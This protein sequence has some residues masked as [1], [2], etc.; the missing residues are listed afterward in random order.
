MQTIETW[1]SL[2]HGIIH[3]GDNKRDAS[4]IMTCDII[5][6]MLMSH[7]IYFAKVYFLV[8]VYLCQFGL[9]AT[10]ILRLVATACLFGG[11]SKASRLKRRSQ[12]HFAK[13]L[14]AF[15]NI[16]KNFLVERQ[17]LLCDSSQRQCG[18]T[19]WQQVQCFSIESLI[20][21]PVSHD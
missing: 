20:P 4:K 11:K 9:G 8:R 3:S 17:L 2:V 14:T 15:I 13:S 6:V 10:F 1:I 12:P 21:K 7:V 5:D 16:S 19:S 18:M